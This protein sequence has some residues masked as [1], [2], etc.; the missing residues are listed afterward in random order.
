MKSLLKNRKDRFFFTTTSNFFLSRACW[1][2]VSGSG[3]FAPAP[4]D[5]QETTKARNQSRRDGHFLT[6]K[7]PWLVNQPPPPKAL[8]HTIH[9]TGIFTNIYHEN[10]PNVGKYNIHGYM[11]P[12]GKGKQWGGYVKGGSRLTSHVQQERTWKSLS[13]CF[14]NIWSQQYWVLLQSCSSVFQAY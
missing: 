7:N 1:L 12:M 13:N 10:Q 8:T 14:P 11:D 2:W 9:G 4:M 5:I 6:S 3:N